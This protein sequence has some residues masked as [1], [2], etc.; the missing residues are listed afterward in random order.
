MNVKLRYKEPAGD[1]SKLLQFPLTGKPISLSTASENFRFAAAVAS[2]GMVLRESKYKGTGDFG[3]VQS[4]A[5][6]AVGYD[7]E[8]YRKEFLQLA[9]NAALLKGKQAT[10]KD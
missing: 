1:V 10:V 7:K 8:G 9:E 5:K 3:L 2:F 6:N 4:L